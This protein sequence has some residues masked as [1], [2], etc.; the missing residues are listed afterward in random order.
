MCWSTNNYSIELDHELIS[1]LNLIKSCRL[2]IPFFFFW[3]VL[4]ISIGVVHYPPE[5]R[6]SSFEEIYQ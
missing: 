1:L 4:R 3:P 6:T 5:R 2:F